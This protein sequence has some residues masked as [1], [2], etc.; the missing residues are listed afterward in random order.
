MLKKYFQTNQALKKE[1][2]LLNIMVKSQKKTIH[3]LKH[4]RKRVVK[5]EIGK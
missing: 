2:E 3:E 5:W 1:N 4:K